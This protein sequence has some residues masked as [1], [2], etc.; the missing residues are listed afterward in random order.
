MFNHNNHGAG[1]MFTRGGQVVVKKGFG[2]LR[3]LLAELEAEH[4]GADD[5]VVYHFR[6]ATQARRYQMTQPFPLTD[7]EDELQAWDA[8]A[9]FGVAHNGI[10]Q[11][12]SNGNPLMSDT[13]LYIRD[14][15][16]PRIK[17]ED[18]IT[19]EL[20]SGIEAETGASKLAI[21]ASSGNVYLTGRWIYEHG[22]FYSNDSY[23][24][25]SYRY[26]TLNSVKI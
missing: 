2:E 24:D 9:S 3:E 21:L 18:D 10:I 11:L 1:Y 17:T 19:R 22:L 23:Q 26:F 6:I 4:F 20:L 15:L 12:T 5:V 13:A 14:Y 7:N 8:R 16:S 25:T